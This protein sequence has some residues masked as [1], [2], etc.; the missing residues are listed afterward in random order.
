VRRSQIL[1]KAARLIPAAL[2]ISGASALL[3][4]SGCSDSNDAGI[5]PD[6]VSQ[7]D[8]ST[9][10][11]LSEVQAEMSLT[12]EQAAEVESALA[13]WRN[14]AAR[15]E[16]IED[17]LL[18]DSPAIAFLSRA[19]ASLDEA[20]MIAL[21]Q[22]AG[23]AVGARA[24]GLRP[25]PGERHTSVIPGI[26]GLFHGLELTQEQVSA[27]RV[28]LA[29]AREDIMDL[30]DQYRDG[31]ISE[32]ELR[33]AR[34]AVRVDLQAAIADILTEE[35]NAELDANKLD[36]LARRLTQLLA[37]YDARVE[38]RIAHLDA[39][40]DL[41]AEQEL[42]ITAVIEAAKPDVE[43][44]LADVEAGTMTA[45]EAWDA[46]RAI[47]QATAD[48]VRLELTAEQIAILD[49]LRVMHEPCRVNVEV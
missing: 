36:I 46:F 34:Q 9:V 41:T 48:D 32:E 13:A 31:M 23:R 5:N 35:Q 10:P 40:L 28:A 19:A 17:V 29:A 2:L 15:S 21:R 4:S 33:D 43:A 45:A 8:D 37:R 1:S 49:E 38:N 27:I 6:P 47:Q 39:L 26:R 42:S 24:D 25:D 16:T 7:E 14:A 44:L 30:C 12:P 20:Q 18:E 3:L 11:S 22:M